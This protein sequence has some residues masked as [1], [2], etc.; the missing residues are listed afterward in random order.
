MRKAFT[1]ILALFVFLSVASAQ[2]DKG[3]MLIGGTISASTN[4]AESGQN[5]QKNRFFNLTPSF[6][7]FY[8][9]NRLAGVSLGI[10]VGRQDTV[11]KSVSYSAGVFLRQY[12]PMGKSFYLFGEEGLDYSRT[13]SRSNTVNGETSQRTNRLDFS[14]HP[15]LAYGATRRIQLELLFPALVTIGYSVSNDDR[16]SPGSRQRY[17]NLALNAG[18]NFGRMLSDIGFGIR[19]L[20]PK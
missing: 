15:G 20:L 13:K 17:R 19:Y 14:V 16:I 8:K 4:K 11:S 10:G 9:E 3:S 5:E 1:L 6:G 7:Q 18:A 12:L 2:Y